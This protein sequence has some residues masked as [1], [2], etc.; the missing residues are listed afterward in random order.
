M[1]GLNMILPN[2]IYEKTKSV[3]NRIIE[4][5]FLHYQKKT[6]K[7]KKKGKTLIGLTMHMR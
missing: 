3:L 1:I 2:P 6:K 5:L 7:K 4:E